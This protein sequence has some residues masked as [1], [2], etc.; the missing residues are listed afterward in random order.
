MNRYRTSTLARVLDDA[1]NSRLEDSWI[2]FR[3]AP[4]VALDSECLVIS[5][6]EEPGKFAASLGFPMEG[7]DAP[8]I[9][10]CMSWAKSQSPKPSPALQ[11]YAFRYYWRFDAFPIAA[12]APD[13][14]PAAEVRAT[15]ALEFY[16]S[17]GSERQQV[18]CRHVGCA[19]GAI[20]HSVLCR[21]HHYEM[22]RREPCPFVGDA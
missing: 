9:E 17:L 3:D 5:D 22:I 20:T 6:Y 12:W 18:R 4:D 11:L 19:S 13:P 2:Y 10:D 8:T 16:R 1:T 21:A 14:P 7:L 15:L